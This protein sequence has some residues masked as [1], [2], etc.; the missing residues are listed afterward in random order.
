[1]TGPPKE[2]RL[3]FIDKMIE[4]GDYEVRA[5]VQCGLAMPNPNEYYRMT[6]S[7]EQMKAEY[8]LLQMAKFTEEDIYRISP[9]FPSFSPYYILIAMEIFLF[10]YF[11][12]IFLQ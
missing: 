3:A 8:E 5:Y 2:A 12:W 1:M 9:I 11:V 6:R 4:S 10:G 7:Y